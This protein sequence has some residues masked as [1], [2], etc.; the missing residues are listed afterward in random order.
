VLS[1]PADDVVLDGEEVV[2]KADGHSVFT[3]LRTTRGAA[4]AQLV[5]STFLSSTVRTSASCR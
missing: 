3:A 1:L 5:A 2:L 4:I